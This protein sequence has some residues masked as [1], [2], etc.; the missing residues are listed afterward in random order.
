MQT[1]IGILGL[2]E[3]GLS[4]AKVLSEKFFVIGWDPITKTEK[5]E[6]AIAN[7][8][9]EVFEKSSYILVFTPA[10]KTLKALENVIQHGKRPL[11][12]VDFS[13]APAQHKMNLSNIASKNG[14]NFIDVAIMSPVRNGVRNTNLLASGSSVLNLVEMLKA[15]DIPIEACGERPG[16]ASKRK[17]TRSILV[18]GLTSVMIESLR[19]AEAL[20]IEDWFSDHLI[21]FLTNLEPRNIEGF[22]SG[23]AIHHMRRIEEMK[24]SAEMASE[25]GV[26]PNMIEGTIAVLKSINEFGVPELKI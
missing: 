24:A 21:E 26:T 22:L 12:F 19:T 13:T 14:L 17:L 15:A 9:I 1:N 6:F 20:E 11:T 2:G 18:K 7:E 23:T 5:L 16:E 3:A 25:A 10:S 8:P 4:Y